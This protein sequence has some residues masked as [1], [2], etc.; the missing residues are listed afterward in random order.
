MADSNAMIKVEHVYK[1]YRAVHALEDLSLEVQ[2]GAVYGLIGPNGAG[3]TT[4]LRILAA[5]LSPSAGLVWLDGEEVTQ[6]P[7]ASSAIRRKVGYM[8]DF[9][10]VYPDLTSAEY[11]EFYAGI[12]GVARRNHASAIKDLLELVNLSDKRDAPVE[13]LSRGMKQRLCLARALVH[14]PQILLLDEPASGLDP[15]ARVEFRELLRTLQGMGKTIVVSSH[16]LLDLAEMCS[17][18]AIIR[19]GRLVI[20]G[21]VERVIRAL[22]GAQRVEMRVL[23]RADEAMQLLKEMPEISSVSLEQENGNGQVIHADFTG[24]DLAL[25][26]I[27]AQLIAKNVLVV[28]FA[29]IKAVDRLEEVYMNVMEG[30]ATI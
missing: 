19:A 24:N 12:S 25:H 27:L 21:D 17:N 28:S 6:S 9:F 4:L 20:E 10:G 30:V 18:I 3:K 26:H 11:L 29:P 2:Q 15:G 16:I 8:P 14:D 7:M 23:E 13:T 5:L 1:R 22:G